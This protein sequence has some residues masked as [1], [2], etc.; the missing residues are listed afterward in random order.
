M[1]CVRGI[2]GELLRV[3]WNAH[4]PLGLKPDPFLG[5]EGE[6]IN[7]AA[8]CDDEFGR[9]AIDGITGGELLGAR[10]QEIFVSNG[11]AFRWGW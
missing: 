6:A 2:D 3:L 5:V 11:A 9:G 1:P 10:E 8:N 4:G 7:T